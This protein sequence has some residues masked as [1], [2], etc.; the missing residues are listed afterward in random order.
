MSDGKI[1]VEYMALTDLLERRHPGN[2]KNHD[3]GRLI[4]AFQT[5]GY[6]SPGSI[7]EL[8]GLFLCGHGR[9]EALQMMRQQSMAAPERI[10]VRPDD[11]YVPTNRGVTFD[12]PLKVKAYLI[13]DNELTILGGW[14]EPQL[15]ALLQEI[16][17]QDKQL[18]EVVFTGDKLD[19]LLRDL[20]MQDEPPTDQGA[21][22][23][24]AAELQEKWQIE[25]GQ[26]W[27]LGR[28][29]IMYGDS[30]S[31]VDV[32]K[33]INGV[34]IDAVVTDPPYGMN[35]D[36][37][38]KNSEPRHGIKPSSGYEAV[39]G[40]DKPFNPAFFFDYFSDVKEQFW[41]GAD[42]YREYLP[43][44]GSWLVWDKRDGLPEFDFTLSEFELCWS[45]ER[46]MRKVYGVRWFGAFGLETEDTPKRIHPTQKPVRL[47][48]AIIELAKA[49]VIIDP[50]LGSGS[51]LM[52]CETLDKSCIGI[53]ISPE[54]C[55]VTIQRWVDAT[56][57]RPELI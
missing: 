31:A 20:Q 34:V 2:P 48:G 4:E 27:Q 52:A 5:F 42:Y 40:D 10:D 19:D 29:K 33:V 24:K 55:A 9:T 44:G 21:Q 14:D 18:L 53:E 35:L 17:E 54:Y 49:S 1:Y 56:G 15:A 28:H 57:Q 37:S 39:I 30:C 6:V 8:T 23:D 51:T 32:T 3:I 13:A 36:T 41:F 38:Y 45:K 26:I 43:T 46:H 25:R 16:G 12:N 11:W 47:L 22:V 7:D 50:F